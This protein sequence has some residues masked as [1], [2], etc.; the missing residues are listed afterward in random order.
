MAQRK[1]TEIS[2]DEVIDEKT[3]LKQAEEREKERKIQ[4]KIEKAEEKKVTPRGSSRVDARNLTEK[5]Q[6]RKK[7]KHG[8]KYRRIIEQIEKEKEYPV[9]EAIDLVLKTSITKFDA[10]VEVHVRINPKE[11]NIRGTVTLPGGVTKERNIV[12]VT[13]KN[14]DEIIEKIKTGK[15]DF[16]ILVADLKVMPKMAVLAK[17]L[18]P[19]G[20][21]PSP[22][23]GTAVS[24]V[25][26]T[27]EELKGGKVEFRADKSNIIHFALGK[28]S[29]GP[30]KIKQNYDALISHLPKRIDSIYLTTS[31][32]P[33]VK[34][35]KK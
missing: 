7:P 13:E 15:L 9:L 11:K 19:K 31:M 6:T 3:I 34:V 22:K 21:M 14:A 8:K 2:S 30:G 32:G 10:T 26:G 20:L 25:A 27:I 28:V 35:A 5:V 18:G 4:E 12:G 17:I 29:F 1:V 23:A 33:S 16:D 24:N